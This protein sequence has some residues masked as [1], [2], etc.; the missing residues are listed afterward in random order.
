MVVTDG[1]EGRAVTYQVPLTYV[2]ARFPALE[3]G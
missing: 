1:S 2:R 3:V